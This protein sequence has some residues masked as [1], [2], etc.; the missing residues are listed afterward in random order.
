MASFG[1]VQIRNMVAVGAVT[2]S[3]V[4]LWF[5]T[6]VT[7]EHR[8][9][10]M[11]PDDHVVKSATVVVP[12]GNLSDN[13]VA[14]DLDGLAAA[15]RH[16]YRV[17][18]TVDGTPLGTGRVHTVPAKYAG[19]PQ[20][21]YLAFMSCH[22]PFNSPDGTLSDRS[23]RMLRLAPT[24]LEQHDAKFVVMC[25]DQIYADN[26]GT[27]SLFD[28]HYTNSKVHPGQG[29]IL[30]WPAADVRRA[31]QQHYRTYY[32]MNELRH[33][34]A[35]YPCYPI[36]DDHEIVD[37]WGSDPVHMTDKWAN[38]REGALAAYHD[39]QGSRIG[40]PGT[41]PPASYHYDF[42][43]GAIG[44]FVMDIR[45]QR[46]ITKGQLYG[47]GQ[48]DDLKAF[49]G[50][51][52]QDSHQVLFIVV[53]VPVVHLPEWLAN[54]GAAI[55]GGRVD[56]PDHW[57]Y[58]K[59]VGARDALLRVLHDHQVAN[60]RQKMA[61]L[62]GDVHIGVGFGIHWIGDNKPILYQFTSSAISNRLKRTEVF[63]S[64]LGPGLVQTIGCDWGGSAR[65]SLIGSQGGSLSPPS[66]NPFGGLNVGIVE[67]RRRGDH[68]TIRL[69]LVGYEPDKE[70]DHSVM[71]DSGEL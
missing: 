22:Q 25:G 67:V 27:Y 50:T 8:I 21:F 57:S 3:S 65:A 44:V 60:P 38:L 69:K 40:Y 68:S 43:Y 9:D 66:N 53:S 20:I 15:R 63:F 14:V 11:G 7:G 62:S 36:L 29:S 12:Q 70:L 34:Y 19:P 13:T 2:S 42:D 23:M 10:V 24:V 35:N 28:P 61:L 71:F 37:D 17:V 6:A 47:Q 26:P 54:V 16:S 39:Y 41:V 55:V 56:F 64:K 30:E 46:D 18:R 4:R 48:L 32:A 58:S 52:T 5:R 31:Y 1:E 59:N 49:L 51:H 33:V 45:T